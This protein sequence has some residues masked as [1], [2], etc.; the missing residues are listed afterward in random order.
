MK[1]IFFLIFIFIGNISFGQYTVTTDTNLYQTLSNPTSL[2]N[3]A[4]WDETSS[5]T[6]NFNFGF[7]IY[8]VT[9][10]SLNLKAGGG[11]NFLGQSEHELFVFHTPFGGYMLK[12]KG[13]LSSQSQIKYEIS[14]LSGNQILKIEWQNAGLTQWYPTSNSNDFVTFQ[15]WL[16]ENDSHFEVRFG[17]SQTSPGTFGYPDST[18]DENPGPSIKLWFNDSSSVLSLEGQ[19][20]APSYGFYDLTEPQYYFIDG[21]PSMGTTIHFTV[22]Q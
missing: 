21:T 22:Q 10:D 4:I 2:N 11:L 20:N 5:F 3:G 17:N 14:G 6:I 1:N 13:I 15:I 19:P 8:G 16:F 18:N 9:Y 7:T 12:D